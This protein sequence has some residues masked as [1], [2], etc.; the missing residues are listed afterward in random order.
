MRIKYTAVKGESVSAFIK[1]ENGYF[2]SWD[3]DPTISSMDDA[4]TT[5]MKQCELWADNIMSA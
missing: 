2:T 1:N 4:V 3:A 5:V